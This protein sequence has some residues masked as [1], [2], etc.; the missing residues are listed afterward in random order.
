MQWH[1]VQISKV[2]KLKVVLPQFSDG[3]ATR[4]TKV[5][6]LKYTV[7]TIAFWPQTWNFGVPS[8]GLQLCKEYLKTNTVALLNHA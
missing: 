3:E 6:T 1:I 5:S 4:S 8:S 2:Q 7:G